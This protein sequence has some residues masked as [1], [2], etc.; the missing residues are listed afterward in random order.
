MTKTDEI[1]NKVIDIR[2][3]VGKMEE[4]LNGINGAVERHNLQ[5]NALQRWIW[6][7]AGVVAVVALALQFIN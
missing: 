6:G 5:I 3:K 2:I 7:A 1:L 4:H